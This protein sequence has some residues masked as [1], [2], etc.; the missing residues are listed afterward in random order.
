MRRRAAKLCA[1][2]C[3][4]LLRAN[5]PRATQG[6]RKAG[7]RDCTLQSLTAGE[8]TAVEAVLATRQQPPIGTSVALN[9]SSSA[10]F[11]ECGEDQGALSTTRPF[12]CFRHAHLYQVPARYRIRLIRAFA[13]HGSDKGEPAPLGPLDRAEVPAEQVAETNESVG[14]SC[15]SA[16]SRRSRSWRSE[17]GGAPRQ[18]RGSLPHAED[19]SSPISR[20]ILA[21][22]SQCRGRE[23][24]RATEAVAL[25]LVPALRRWASPP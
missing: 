10:A 4:E 19:Y 12:G 22:S 14:M 18:F 23:S 7:L 8:R 17:R 13:L 1:K 21:A 16:W 20:P 24:F 25:R 2:E 6:P 11:L 15:I 5:L 9:L 3:V